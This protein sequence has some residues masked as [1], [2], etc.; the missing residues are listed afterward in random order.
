MSSTVDPY[1][2]LG[3]P[4]TANSNEIKRAYHSLARKYHP[5]RFMNRDP[6]IRDQAASRFS[7]IAA[8]YAI[9]E[10]PVTKAQYDHIYKYGGFDT[11]ERSPAAQMGVGY[12]CHCLGARTTAGLFIPSRL[13][14]PLQVLLGRVIIK[15][16]H[17]KANTTHIIN[18]TR[19]S[20]S[21]IYYPDGRKEVLADDEPWYVNAWKE[22]RTKISLCHNPC[23]AAVQ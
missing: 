9:L 22:F 18:N 5:D 4:H 7:Q 13:Q 23:V 8:S 3:V 15:E 14:G 20:Q 11:D 17:V 21:V 6:R 2:N 1:K 12:S 10:D 16:S 19:V